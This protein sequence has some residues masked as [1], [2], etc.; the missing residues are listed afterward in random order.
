M[1]TIIMLGACRQL[2]VRASPAACQAFRTRG[3]SSAAPL[4]SGW[5]EVESVVQK[6]FNDYSIG[7]DAA[8]NDLGKL[9]SHNISS[10]KLLARVDAALMAKM[11]ISAGGAI[12]INDAIEAFEA[13][14]ARSKFPTR[15]NTFDRKK[16]AL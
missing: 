2:S 4:A 9:K 12:T 3:M 8:A 6:S 13:T 10:M 11:D 14:E 1:G 7:S 16:R 15:Q 5:A